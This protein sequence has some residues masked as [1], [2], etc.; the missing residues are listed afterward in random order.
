MADDF[1]EEDEPKEEEHGEEEEVPE[2]F[3]P[4][5]FFDDLREEASESPYFEDFT[6]EPVDTFAFADEGP[7]PSRLDNL[8]GM[9]AAQRA[10]IAVMLLGTACILSAFCLLVFNKI[11][12]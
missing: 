8:F 5:A 3:R 6:E 1:N 2:A 11:A 9:T 4:S 7:A 12:F 10:V